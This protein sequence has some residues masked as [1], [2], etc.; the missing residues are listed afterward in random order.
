MVSQ[1]CIHLYKPFSDVAISHGLLQ[2]NHADDLPTAL[3]TF[4]NISL[5]TRH[6][7]SMVNGRYV[8]RQRWADALVYK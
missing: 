3:N 8:R 1:L 4:I 6:A 5:N 7:K 2:T